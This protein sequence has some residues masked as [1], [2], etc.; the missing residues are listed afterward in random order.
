MNTGAAVGKKE[1]VKM[2]DEERKG[3]K[4]ALLQVRARIHQQKDLS[5]EK[6]PYD[7][8]V[9][10]VPELERIL[11]NLRSENDIEN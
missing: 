7:V 9:L 2:T 10:T 5:I 6:F 8:G 1:G 11:K 3:Y 4:K